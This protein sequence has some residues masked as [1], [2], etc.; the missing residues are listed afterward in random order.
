MLVILLVGCGGGGGR[1]GD[2]QADAGTDP[3]DVVEE[4]AAGDPG[5]EDDMPPVAPCGNGV[6]DGEEACDG[7]VVDC[8]ALTASWSAGTAPCREDCTGYDVDGCT[9]TEPAPLFEVVKPAGRDPERWGLAR[10]NDGTPFTFAVRMPVEHT[11]TWVFS[12]QGGGFC[13]DYSTPCEGRETE[14]TTTFGEPDGQ[15]FPADV[16]GIGSTDPTTNPAFHDAVFVYA[17]Y[18]T[19]DLWA[20]RGEVR[21]P[22]TAAPAG[23]WYFAGRHAVDAMLDILVGRYGL[24]DSDASTRVLFSGFSA[25]GFGVALNADQVVDALPNASADGRVKL[26]IDGGWITEDWDEPTARFGLATTGDRDVMRTF[27]EDFPLTPGS[28]CEA[29]VTHPGDCAFGPLYH[30]VLTD[31]PPGGLGLDVMIQQSLTDDVLASIHA[32]TDDPAMVNAYAEAQLA[33][34]EDVTWLFAS[35]RSY[36]VVSIWDESWTVGDPPDTFR[37]VLL[38]FWEGETPQRVIY[39]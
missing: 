38:R 5:D 17:F 32:I 15:R 19:S 29:S 30:P 14:L 7:D 24:D 31:P 26:L 33:S 18:C 2:G 27:F 16:G 35:Y 11:D 6:V 23:G 36:H 28:V 22:T 20:G 25:G 34:L 13:D 3:E 4:D 8:T 1:D 9:V 10:C 12:L 39:E 37:E 21:T